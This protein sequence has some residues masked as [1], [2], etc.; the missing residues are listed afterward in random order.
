[1]KIKTLLFFSIS[2]AISA[3]LSCN[4][5]ADTD[6]SN[7]DNVEI[8]NSIPPFQL[9]AQYPHNPTFFTEGLEYKDSAIFESTGLNGKSKLVK[10]DLKT[11]KEFASI[12]LDKKYFGEG[13]T[14]L[15]GKI[16]QL[17]YK[18]EKCLVYDAKTFKKIN[19]LNY[20]GEGWGMT[21]DGKQIIMSNGSNNL[22]YRNAITFTEE[23]IVAI[24][25][26]NG[27]LGNINEL[28]FVDGFIYANIWYK[29]YIVKID[30]KLGKVVAKFDFSN[31]I[32]QYVVGLSEESVMNGI[33][34][35]PLNKSFYITGKYWPI[36]FEVKFN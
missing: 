19:E 4:S 33:A 16:F 13:V 1:M 21:N 15:N 9:I 8:N 20:K 36:L 10:Y 17:T 14:L 5:N 32:K 34:Y 18:E 11:G 27:P 28:E 23:N 24:F 22:I 26:E 29:N 31:L 2:I 25:D 6:N 35:N 7:N 3:F 30:P 12:N